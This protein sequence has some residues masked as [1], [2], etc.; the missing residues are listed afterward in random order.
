MNDEEKIK[1][2]FYQYEDAGLIS[3]D[4]EKVLNCLDE[5][6]I[7]IGIGEQ[8][9]VSCMDDVRQIFISGLKHDKVTK[10]SLSFEQLHIL[11]HEEGFA[12]LCAHVIVRAQKGSH[13]STS[14]FLQSLTFVRRGEEWKICALH[15][16][17]PIVTE[18]SVEA[19]PLKFAEKT[20]QSL[21]EKIGEA[22]YLAEE[23]YRQ[24]V[25][26][27]TVA[28]YIINFSTDT[29]EKCQLNGN[30]C[31]HVEPGTRYEEFLFKKSPQYVI[32]DDR[33]Q[34][35]ETL[36]LA[37]VREA[38]E[39]G[40]NEVSCEYQMIC[41]D[42]SLRWMVTIIRLLTD[43]VT[44]EKKGIMYVK[45]ID[46]S[47]RR[48]LEMIR[49]AARDGM[50]GALNKA[51]FIRQA[52]SELTKTL[53]QAA[54]IMIDVDHFKNINDTCGH[55]T[56][57]RVLISIAGILRDAFG[58]GAVTGRLGGDEFAVF[59]P[60]APEHDDLCRQLTHMMTS[61]RQI[62]LRKEDQVAV[63]CS[64]G[65]AMCHSGSDIDQIYRDADTALYR[66]K[67]SGKNRFAFYGAE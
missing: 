21:K 13:V 27:D 7:G 50:T 28:F 2:V 31:V 63:T 46:A 39:S 49:D 8:G 45:D 37:K 41:P 12:N 6:I 66:A 32:D 33:T 64:V 42:K 4:L 23:Q 19:Y 11:V 14:R 17:T 35:L 47:K 22:A 57:D 1:Q 29:F 55:P 54:F 24:A 26:A 3:M 34:F 38:Y 48:E 53:T 30:L 9:F 67:H 58:P 40:S 25:L 18:E 60:Q 65:I 5:K 56:G 43:A 59:I 62:E 20:L 16:S 61:I 36:S 51:A 15:A 52:A 10:H 44:G